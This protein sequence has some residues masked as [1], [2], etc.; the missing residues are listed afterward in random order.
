MTPY[1]W[2]LR[3]WNISWMRNHDATSDLMK[4][5]PRKVPRRT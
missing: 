2:M 1:M 3:K 5:I 4:I